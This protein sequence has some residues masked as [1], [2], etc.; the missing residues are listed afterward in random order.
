MKKLLLIATTLTMLL[1][2]MVFAS[3]EAD[4]LRSSMV[5]RQSRITVTSNLSADE[6]LKEAIAYTGNSSEGDY[7][8]YNT[9][10]PNFNP[11]IS[12]S[13]GKI[14]YGFNYISSAAQE[15]KVDERISEILKELSFTDED[16][17]TKI[18]SIHS[19][20]RKN[21]E[22][23]NEIKSSAY[24]Q[25]I[26]GKSNCRGFALVFYKLAVE[27]GI[28]TRICYNESSQHE[29]NLCRLGGYWYIVDASQDSVLL[30]GSNSYWNKITEN[31]LNNFNIENVSKTDYKYSPTVKPTEATTETKPSTEA[32]TEKKEEPTTEAVKP[33]EIPTTEAIKPTT[34]EVK[35]TVPTTEAKKEEG[36]TVT[37]PNTEAK[38]EIKPAEKTPSKPSIT[39]QKKYVYRIK[40]SSKSGAEIKMKK[41]KGKMYFKMRQYTKIDN[42]TVWSKWSNYK[43]I[44]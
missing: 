40:Y 12:E 16:D 27:S 4:G 14:T 20:M 30:K 32:T 44:Y 11:S 33:I 41:S 5:K 42:N 34:Q 38:L 17:Y 23:T 19:W 21:C 13:N 35:P 31:S 25:L 6:I 15:K 37:I 36:T 3:T 26:N 22:F 8:I 10:Y 2:V 39:R 1:P 28:D 18:K 9:Y 29:F 43:R 7:L 24:E